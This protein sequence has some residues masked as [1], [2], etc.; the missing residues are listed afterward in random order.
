MN[1]LSRLISRVLFLPTNKFDEKQWSFLWT[2]RCRRVL[3][4]YPLLKTTRTTSQS[5][6][7]LAPD[8]V[9][10]APDITVGTGGLLHHRFTLALIGGI[11]SVALSIFRHQRRRDSSR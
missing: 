9:Y 1:H 3:A 10:Q 11:L 5:L 7:D 2:Q 6:F 4:I 8:G